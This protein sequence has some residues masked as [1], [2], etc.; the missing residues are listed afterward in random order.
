MRDAISNGN[1]HDFVASLANLAMIRPGVAVHC[2][3]QILEHVKKGETS[4]AF[5][6]F[7]G[8]DN[9]LLHL[10]ESGCIVQFSGYDGK[11]DAKEP[12]TKYWK[13]LLS[14]TAS[15]ALPN[16]DNDIHGTAT[17]EHFARIAEAAASAA[18]ISLDRILENPCREQK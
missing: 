5:E 18:G 4:F 13:S 17:E 16:K 8:A 15:Q 1:P 7:D 11:I 3:R 2:L 10:Q 6:A 9:V 12:W 14:S